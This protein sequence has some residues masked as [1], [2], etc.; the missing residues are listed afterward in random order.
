[1]NKFPQLFRHCNR[2]VLVAP[3][4]L[5]AAGIAAIAS[6]SRTD[7]TFLTREVIIQSVALVIGLILVS[8][9]TYAGYRYFTDL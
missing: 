7:K 4:A 9:I 6:V 8:V 3:V 5:S 1:M 2:L